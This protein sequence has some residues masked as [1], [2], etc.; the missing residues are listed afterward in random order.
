MNIQAALAATGLAL[1]CASGIARTDASTDAQR[2]S[3]ARASASTSPTGER[4]V[5]A[6]DAPVGDAPEP[7]G[8]LTPANAS[9]AL[10]VV[11]ALV[12]LVRRR[13][14]D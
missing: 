10:A 3:S 9:L 13:G 5:L 6:P 2:S 14:F 4:P 12:L 1:A 7:V 11:G 8:W